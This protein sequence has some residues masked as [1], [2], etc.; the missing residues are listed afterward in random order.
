MGRITLHQ[1]DITKH[2]EAG[3]TNVSLLGGAL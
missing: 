3:A 1:G 2:G